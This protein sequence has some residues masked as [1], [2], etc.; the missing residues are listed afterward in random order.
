MYLVFS[1]SLFLDVIYVNTLVLYGPVFLRQGDMHQVRMSAV[2]YQDQFI[3][4]VYQ[5]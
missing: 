3:P 1:V 2:N 4:Q 5:L